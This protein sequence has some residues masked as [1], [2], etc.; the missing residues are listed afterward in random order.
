MARS[1]L[2]HHRRTAGRCRWAAWALAPALLLFPCAAHA[3]ALNQYSVQVLAQSGVSTPGF[4][5][6]DKLFEIGQMNNHGQIALVTK[7]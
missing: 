4:N 2:L 7:T 5:P 1:S 3:D 6:I